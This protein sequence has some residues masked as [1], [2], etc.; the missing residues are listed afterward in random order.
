[1]AIQPLVTSLTHTSGDSFDIGWR[2]SSTGLSV[3]NIDCILT[4]LIEKKHDQFL[5]VKQA[6]ILV[7]DHGLLFRVI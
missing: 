1:M 3:L 7:L 6:N 5:V 2:D 4:E